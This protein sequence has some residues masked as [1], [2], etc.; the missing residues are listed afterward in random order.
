MSYT[1]HATIEKADAYA[2]LCNRIGRL[3][4]RGTPR[5]GGRHVESPETWD[6]TGP[7]PKGWRGLVQHLRPNDATDYLV[8]VPREIAREI[9]DSDQLSPDELQLRSDTTVFAELPEQ[10][11]VADVVDAVAK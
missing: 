2:A 3:P 1:I 7:R 4:I 10:F 6:G 5:G 9:E 8:V 11:R